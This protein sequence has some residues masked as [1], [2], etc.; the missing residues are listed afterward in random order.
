MLKGTGDGAQV[1][2]AEARRVVDG[3]HRLVRRR[4]QRR[5]DKRQ[6][7]A[8]VRLQAAEIGALV[9]W[10]VSLGLVGVERREGWQRG[11]TQLQ[12]EDLRW[13]AGISQSVQSPPFSGEWVVP[14]G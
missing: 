14:P 3:R 4:R 8:E 13:G 9:P 1:E 6:R 7:V 10:A 12:A 5:V 11:L 2:V